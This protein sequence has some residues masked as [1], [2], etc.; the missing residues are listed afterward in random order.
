[1]ICSHCC[2]CFFLV[3]CARRSFPWDYCIFQVSPSYVRYLLDLDGLERVLKG[4]YCLFLAID[5]CLNICVLVRMFAVLCM[6]TMFDDCSSRLLCLYRYCA[7]FLDLVVLHFCGFGLSPFLFPSLW[8]PCSFILYTFF[9]YPMSFCL[10]RCRRA[11]L[12]DFLFL[13]CRD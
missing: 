2:R 10:H 8:L 6:V 12:H 4:V 3:Q 13:F 7:C 1:M 9:S 11:L 5:L